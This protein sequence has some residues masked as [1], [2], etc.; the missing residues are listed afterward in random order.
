MSELTETAVPMRPV[1]IIAPE[2]TI[3][4]LAL[5]RERRDDLVKKAPPRP[6]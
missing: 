4:R 5:L 2:E 6:T 1:H 3:D